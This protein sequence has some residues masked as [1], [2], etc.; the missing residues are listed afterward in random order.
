MSVIPAEAVEAAAKAS[1]EK[2]NSD[3]WISGDA[4]DLRWADR[5]AYL[6]D[7]K[8]MLEAAAPHMLAALADSRDGEL[9][10]FPWA[11]REWLRGANV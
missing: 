9:F 11:Q 6:D 3:P 8:V 4:D 7:A 10:R 1:W 5:R 2:S